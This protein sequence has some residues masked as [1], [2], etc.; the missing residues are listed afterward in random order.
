VLQGLLNNILKIC[1]K[2]L[3]QSNFRQRVK[4]SRYRNAGANEERRYSSKSFLTSALD[5]GESSASRPSRDLS[6]GKDFG[7]HWIGGWVDLRAG[8]DTRGYRKNV[9]PLPRI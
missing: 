5:G 4:L 2:K 1:E 9:L 6:P 8:M 7:T 3:S